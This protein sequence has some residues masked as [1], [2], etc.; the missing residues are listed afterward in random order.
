MNLEEK[1]KAVIENHLSIIPQPY[2]K[3]YEKAVT[4]KSLSAAVKA[5]CLD[6]MRWKKL[7]VR[8]CTSLACPL[9]THRPYQEILKSARNKR[10]LRAES[11]QTE[12]PVPG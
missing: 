4:G 8:K 3:T 9:W 10:D 12:Q 2:R 7:E 5:Q 1:R 11:T 6:C